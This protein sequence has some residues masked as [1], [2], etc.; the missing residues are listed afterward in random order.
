MKEH[1]ELLYLVSIKYIEDELKK[2]QEIVAKHI[3]EFGGENIKE[4]VLGK[5]KLAYPINHVH[6]GT[7]IVVN[8]E[9]ETEGVKKLDTQL[10]L[11]TSIL[12]HLTVAQK[13]KT[14]K[15]IQ[16]E[17]EVQE[18]LRKE[19]EQEL[20]KAD[21]ESTAGLKKAAQPELKPTEEKINVEKSNVGTT[22]L[23]MDDIDKK[24]DE[25]LTDD[26]L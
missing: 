6:Q 8:F 13:Q 2:V 20:E 21:K 9:M 26:L 16:R 1:Y 15:E 14:E 10:K 3:T 24:I 19:K 4:K 18:R 17:Q 11:M 7:Y 22:K 12:R 23:G 25:I 5:Q